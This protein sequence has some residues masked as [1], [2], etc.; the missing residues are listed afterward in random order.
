[1]RT[2]VE[3]AVATRA[4]DSHYYWPPVCSR[5]GCE[6]SAFLGVF[7]TRLPPLCAAW[8]ADEELADL[9]PV[10][11]KND[12]DGRCCYV[13]NDYDDAGNRNL[14]S[15]SASPFSL[16]PSSPSS[17]SS[18][19]KRPFVTGSATPGSMS[20]SSFVVPTTHKS[21]PR[22]RDS[23]AVASYCGGVPQQP[24]LIAR[25]PSM[26]C[27]DSVVFMVNNHR[28]QTSSN[29]SA[30]TA[31]D[32]VYEL[33]DDFRQK[34]VEAL[35]RRYGG[36]LVA[37]RA[38]ITIQRAYRRYSM[39]RKFANLRQKRGTG[40]VVH[41]FTDSGLPSPSLDQRNMSFKEKAGYQLTECGGNFRPSGSAAVVINRGE[42]VRIRNQPL[43]SSSSSVSDTGTDHVDRG[44]GPCNQ[45]SAADSPT[46]TGP[47]KS[48]QFALSSSN[49]KILSNQREVFLRDGG[50][51]FRN[52]CQCDALDLGEHPLEPS[53]QHFYCSLA[54][55]DNLTTFRGPWHK[56]EPTGTHWIPRSDA[57]SSVPVTPPTAAACAPPLVTSAGSSDGTMHK[58][59]PSVFPVWIPRMQV[60]RNGAAS[61]IVVPVKNFPYSSDFAAQSLSSPSS[62]FTS[63]PPPPS[64]RQ[65]HKNEGITSCHDTVPIVV[66]S[67]SARS[68][69]QN[70]MIRKRMYR[71]ALN[72]F[73]KK[74]ERGIQLLVQYGFVDGTPAAVAKFLLVR[75][76]LSRQMIG[77]LLGNLQN[78]FC[79]AVL[80]YFVSEID[81]HDLE[82]DVALRLFQSHFRLPGEAQKI[83]RIME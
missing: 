30:S 80:D 51:S 6:R 17:R 66:P 54:T 64:L 63:P 68:Q 33:S 24:Y 57:S 34:Q 29:D 65:V 72:F 20:L 75:K 4:D 53:P 56:E 3:A 12:C 27:D 1:M 36:R 59:M 16:S 49:Y 70:E 14:P 58:I 2:L 8:Y 61:N 18:S 9:S 44:R 31:S 45:P 22:C 46:S 21:L 41:F 67:T 11:S 60:V 52:K 47:G 62:S 7:F 19:T 25:H 42:A 73:N 38:A 55:Y 26:C 48:T 5:R 35:E 69:E 79:M 13:V 76:G 23:P 50:D 40:R 37:R 74:P 32:Y 82:I 15:L 81:M 77:E 83:E 10:S 28:G 78:S 43:P 71:I 39:A